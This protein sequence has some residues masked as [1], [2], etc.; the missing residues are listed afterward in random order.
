MQLECSD[1]GKATSVDGLRKPNHKEKR[2]ENDPPTK[3]TFAVPISFQFV[4]LSAVDRLSIEQKAN[5]ERRL[6][7]CTPDNHGII[8]TAKLPTRRP[9]F[10]V[11]EFRLI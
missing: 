6:I 10:Y 4:A 9:G 3:L 7:V 5:T 8:F 11:K 1:R 2:D